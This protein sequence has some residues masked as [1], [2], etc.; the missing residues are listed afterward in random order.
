MPLVERALADEE[1][2][3]SPD[4]GGEHARG[5]ERVAS[6]VRARGR[7]RAIR[8]GMGMRGI[9]RSPHLESS[10]PLQRGPGARNVEGRAVPAAPASRPR[11]GVAMT[12]EPSA[13][14]KVLRAPPVGQINF[15]VDKVDVNQRQLERVAKAIEG[16]EIEISVGGGL[17]SFG[18]AYTSW[19]GA[20]WKPGE[21]KYRGRIRVG[22][23]SVVDSAIGRSAIFHECVHALID[24]ADMKPSELQDEVAAYVADALYLRMTKTKPTSPDPLVMAIYTA[25]F[26]VV[27]GHKLVTT[28]GVTLKWQ[29]CD[30]LG[31]AIKAYPDYSRL[32]E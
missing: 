6:H 25:A 17:G 21:T 26:G 32:K 31:K 12:L 24:L 19:K 23:A 14:A 11:P 10:V 2:L 28:P 22:N 7:R 15:K 4:D 9:C 8:D 20:T 29:D 1:R 3:A 16:L 27:D 18:A 13:V 5:M 30:A